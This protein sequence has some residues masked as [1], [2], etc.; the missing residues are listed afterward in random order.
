MGCLCAPWVAVLPERLASRQVGKADL[1][2]PPQPAVVGQ[3]L[4]ES[5]ELPPLRKTQC[6]EG[7][8]PLSHGPAEAASSHLQHS[9]CVGV[10][11][12]ERQ[13]DRLL[14][15]QLGPPDDNGLS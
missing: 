15:R 13:S 5:G 1:E 11:R 9:V 8:K 12:P 4:Q 14:L 6:V 3:R 2:P 7:Q 10:R